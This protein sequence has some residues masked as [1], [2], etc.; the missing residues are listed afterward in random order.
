MQSYQDYVKKYG[1][2]VEM[3]DSVDYVDPIAGK[4][5]EDAERAKFVKAHPHA[6]M[7]RLKFEAK[8]TSL[9]GTG[10]VTWFVD[11]DGITSYDIR[12]DGFKKDKEYT[13]YPTSMLP[14]TPHGWSR[15]WTTGSGKIYRIKANDTL[16]GYSW[17]PSVRWPKRVSEFKVYVN[18]SSYF[19][20]ASGAAGNMIPQIEDYITIDG[21]D[22]KFD[23]K[24]PYFA[25]S[26]ERK[27]QRSCVVSLRTTL[28]LVTTLTP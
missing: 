27:L 10:I 8:P 2:D 16:D 24:K 15:M 17:Y 25:S 6:D 4:K 7:R 23:Y 11:L 20:T 1:K 13:A 5:A 28:Y 3:D 12:Y 9:G 22:T 18:S 19:N 14:Q 26:V 21:V